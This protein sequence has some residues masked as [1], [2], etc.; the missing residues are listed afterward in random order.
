MKKYLWKTGCLALFTVF[1]TGC[2]Q[3][4]VLH[5]PESVVAGSGTLNIIDNNTANANFVIDGTHYRGVW[6]AHKVDESRV[7]AAQYGFAS[8]KYQRYSTG[9]DVYL[10][11]GEAVLFSAQGEK[12]SCEVSFRGSSGRANCVSASGAFEFVIK[13]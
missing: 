9:N 5:T 7:I 1:L 13:G 6:V 2:E 12:L 3:N 10:R 8:Q 4:V 11:R